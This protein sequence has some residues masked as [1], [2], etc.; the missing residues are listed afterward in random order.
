MRIFRDGRIEMVPKEAF[1]WVVAAAT[2][3]SSAARVGCAGLGC[4]MT[5][6]AVH[7]E[8]VEDW[9]ELSVEAG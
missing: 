1:R 3:E 6:H 2:T 5:T 4:T 8:G 9:P 7:V